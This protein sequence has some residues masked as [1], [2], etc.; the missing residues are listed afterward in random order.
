MDGGRGGGAP[1]RRR[2][3][4]AGARGARLRLDDD[5]LREILLLR[6]AACRADGAEAAAD[7]G[8]AR[9]VR[10]RHSA[11]RAGRGARR[12]DQG[13]PPALQNRHVRPRQAGACR[14]LLPRWAHRAHGAL[15]RAL[16]GQ[17]QAPLHPRLRVLHAAQGPLQ[18]RRGRPPLQARRR[19]RL[20]RLRHDA[21]GQ[22]LPRAD[23]GAD[24]LAL[25]LLLRGGAE[26]VLPQRP[27]LLPLAL[28][29]RAQS[30]RPAAVRCLPSGG[31]KC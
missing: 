30:P 22:A 11:D 25:E 19:A 21:H 10:H 2:P 7:A 20:R 28:G 16:D 15:R 24:R 12:R 3:A 23:E 8:V 17:Y 1:R 5:A 9:R 26:A 14:D 31:A 4:R 6:A 27:L 13:L 29:H 18:R